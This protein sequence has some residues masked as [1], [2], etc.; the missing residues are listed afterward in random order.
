MAQLRPEVGRDPA[1]RADAHD[2]ATTS[3]T[4]TAQDSDFYY[5][6]GIARRTT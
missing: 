2:D 6:T 1:L 5:L 4:S 3:S